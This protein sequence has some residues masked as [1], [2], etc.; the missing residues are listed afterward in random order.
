MIAQVQ[1]DS[2]GGVTVT[3]D[4][5]DYTADEDAAPLAGLALDDLLDRA[6]RK[7]VATWLELR[8]DDGDDD[9]A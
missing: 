2:D 9:R 8:S 5:D 6:A 7:A 4:S 3:L 1:I